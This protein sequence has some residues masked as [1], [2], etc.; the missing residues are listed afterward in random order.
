MAKGKA[1]PIKRY[2]FVVDSIEMRADACGEFVK[3]ETHIDSHRFDDL[4]ECIQAQRAYDE[5][6]ENNK[7][8]MPCSFLDF[9]EGWKACA[10]ARE[11][12]FAG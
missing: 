4:P 3:Y 5:R 11:K 2:D 9:Y 12:E 6:K 7:G 8:Y 10:L 1:M